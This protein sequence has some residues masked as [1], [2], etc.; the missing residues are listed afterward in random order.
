MYILVK[1]NKIHDTGAESATSKN[2]ATFEDAQA[3]Y[4]LY[5]HNNAL[6]KSVERLDITILNSDLIP[7]KT[8][9]FVREYALDT[10]SPQ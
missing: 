8:D 7:C 4:W 9:H 10:E 6:D 3:D 1:K 5:L 2:Y